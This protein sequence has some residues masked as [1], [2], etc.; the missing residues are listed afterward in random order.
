MRVQL[1]QLR[2]ELEV[3]VKQ[4]DFQRAAELKTSISQSEA[5]K[6][7]LMEAKEPVLEEI[8][9]EKVTDGKWGDN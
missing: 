1:N 7:S 9:S 8:K 2:E 6:S 3:A 4:Q 5:E